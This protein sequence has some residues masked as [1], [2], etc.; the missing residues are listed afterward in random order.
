MSPKSPQLDDRLETP[1]QLAARV[2]ISERQ[3]RYLIQ[4][5]Q[6]EHVMIGEPDSSA[7]HL[8]TIRLDSPRPLA[9]IFADPGGG[10]DPQKW[11]RLVYYKSAFEKKKDGFRSADHNFSGEHQ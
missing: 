3:V 1:K 9:E 4:T 6:L 8:F 5:H 7:D 2:G 11:A 10:G